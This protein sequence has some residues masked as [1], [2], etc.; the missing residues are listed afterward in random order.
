[1]AVTPAF[2][3]DWPSEYVSLLLNYNEEAADAARAELENLGRLA[4]EAKR[5]VSQEDYNPPFERYTPPFHRMRLMAVDAR[6]GDVI[7]SNTTSNQIPRA[8]MD[9]GVAQYAGLTPQG[10]LAIVNDKLAVPCGAQL[11]A[12]VDPKTGVLGDYTMGWGGRVG[13]P[14]GSWFA[15]G[16][17]METSREATG[18][19]GS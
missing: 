12:F 5:I 18:S 17:R 11:A 9:H 7:W 14:K 4:E 8:N 1:M 16:C 19:A 6:T 15:A 3:I 2:G 13:L 10:Y